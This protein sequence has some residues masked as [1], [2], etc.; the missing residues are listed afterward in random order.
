M[1]KFSPGDM[2]DLLI[3]ECPACLASPLTVTPEGDGHHIVDCGT[4]KFQFSVTSENGEEGIVFDI[5]HA[6]T[7]RTCG[8]EFADASG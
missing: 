8:F 2:W 6:A 7:Q 1:F 3:K 4:C 5:L